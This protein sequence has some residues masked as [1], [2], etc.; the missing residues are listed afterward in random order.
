MEEY[1]S[2]KEAGS[3]LTTTCLQ[4]WESFREEEVEEDLENECVERLV[5]KKLY[6]TDIVKTHERKYIHDLLS[7]SH[8]GQILVRLRLAQQ[9]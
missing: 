5:V 4:T 6:K 8:L 1:N 7:C 2:Y 3:L 9:R